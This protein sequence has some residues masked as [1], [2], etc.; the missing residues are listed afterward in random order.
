[1]GWHDTDDDERQ[2]KAFFKLLARAEAHD[3]FHVPDDVETTHLLCLLPAYHISPPLA[4]RPR[5]YACEQL[6]M[7]AFFSSEIYVTAGVQYNPSCAVYQQ[8]PAGKA[9]VHRAKMPTVQSGKRRHAA[10]IFAAELPRS[11]V[12]EGTFQVR[13]VRWLYRHALGKSFSSLSGCSGLFPTKHRRQV[14]MSGP[15]NVHPPFIGDTEH[16]A[17]I[18]A[19]NTYFYECRRRSPSTKVTDQPVRFLLAVLMV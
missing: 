14:V 18:A 17:L 4:S 16:Q 5:A 12:V 3:I 6:C 15:L 1:M 7:A 19:S 10:H 2:K 8:T 13:D 9:M 11:V